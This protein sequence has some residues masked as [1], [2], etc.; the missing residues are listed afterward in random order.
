MYDMI[1]SGEE[2]ESTEGGSHA[3]SAELLLLEARALSMRADR[4]P[5]SLDIL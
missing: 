3:G 5:R 1:G 2:C 4:A